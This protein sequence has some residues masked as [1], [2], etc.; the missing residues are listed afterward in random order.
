LQTLTVKTTKRKR[1]I[2]VVRISS[3]VI[4]SLLLYLR[5]HARFVP[6]FRKF[7]GVAAER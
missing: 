4:A 7:V 1:V 5:R 2:L 6:I 3:S